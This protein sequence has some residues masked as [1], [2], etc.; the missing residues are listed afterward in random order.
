MLNSFEEHYA[1]LPDELLEEIL[2]ET[3]SISQKVKTMFDQAGNRRSDMHHELFKNSKIRRA[4]E[5]ESPPSPSVAAVDGGQAIERS[6]GADTLIAVAVGIEGL[7]RE[8]NRKWNSIQYANWQDVIQHDAER[9]P[10]L[11]RGIM[12]AL[13]LSITSKAPHEVVILDGSHLTPVIGINSMISMKIDNPLLTNTTE[14]IL[15]G[16]DV[17]NTLKTVMEKDNIIAM[18]KYDS[19]MDIVQTWLKRFNANLDD[20]TAMTMILEADEFT[21]PTQVGQTQ[22][23][24]DFWTGLKFSTPWALNSSKRDKMQTSLN[25]SITNS[26]NRQIYFSYYKPYD[27]SPAY[28]IEM[29][30]RVANNEL[31]LAK[32]LKAI[33][34]QV[35]SPEIREPYP[36]YLADMMAKSVGNAMDALHAGI[37]LELSDTGKKDYLTLITQ[38]YRTER[39]I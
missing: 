34:E 18:V 17:V 5:L 10:R 1:N 22:K 7:V 4:A 39:K 16:Y 38:S 20:R 9:N 28:R 8:D 3:G 11:L 37:Y 14:E 30:R 31:E 21:V 25:S 29:K 26:S 35:V 23:S 33:K 2:K 12:T 27:W 24:S 36:Q 19:S 13:E 6:I 32:V 15:N